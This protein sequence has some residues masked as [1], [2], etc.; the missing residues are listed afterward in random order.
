[1]SGVKG[2]MIAIVGAGPGGLMLARL[3]QQS[4]AQ[5]SVYERDQSCSARVPGSAL[6]LHEGSGL[7][8]LEA[9]GLIDA[10]WANHRPD[11]DR[12]RLTDAD[13][14]ILHDHPG[15]M[16]LHEFRSAGRNRQADRV[17]QECGFRET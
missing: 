9:A 10:F 17:R 12:L 7:T 4:D 5:V 15:R 11:L 2:K 6:D 8:A 13:G 3:L 16:R 1:M 14:R